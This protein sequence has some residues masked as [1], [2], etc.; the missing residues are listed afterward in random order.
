MGTDVKTELKKHNCQPGH[1]EDGGASSR[2]PQGRPRAL[3]RRFPWR[4]G[5]GAV[6]TNARRLKGISETFQ[7]RG[8]PVGKSPEAPSGAQLHGLS[9]ISPGSLPAQLHSA[10]PCSPGESWC[11]LGFGGLHPD[12]KGGLHPDSKG[13]AKWLGASRHLTQ[14]HL[15]SPHEGE[16]WWNCVN[17]AASKA[18]GV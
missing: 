12:S 11:T 8:D 4:E 16:A 18:T 9:S 14:E 5:S 15:G 10:A 3:L 6:C 17:Q 7:A 1:Q 2:V 13:C